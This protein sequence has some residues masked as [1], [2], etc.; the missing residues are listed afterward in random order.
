MA[1]VMENK[2][3]HL[4]ENGFTVEHFKYILMIM[5]GILVFY[6]PYLR[7]LYF[8][9]EQ[10]PA[11]IFSFVILVGVMIYK[12]INQDKVFLKTPIDYC[13][14]GLTMVYALSLLVSVNFRSG[15][16]E[17]LKYAFY[18]ACFYIASQ[19]FKEYRN[20][21]ALLWVI[22]VSIFGVSIISMDSAIGPRGYNSDGSEATFGPLSIVLNNILEGLPLLHLK[23]S[24]FDIFL[25][26]KIYSTLQYSNAFAAL[27]FTVFIMCVVLITNAKTHI[28]RFALSFM[29]Y[30]I[31]TALLF[32]QSRGVTLL[33]PFMLIFLIFSVGKGFRVRTT[34]Y[35]F[36]SMLLSIIISF[37]FFDYILSNSEN[38]MNKWL[39]L[40]TGAIITAF[41]N[42][43]IGFFMGKFEKHWVIGFSMLCVLIV[44][45]T[46]GIIIAFT[47]KEPL[48]LELTSN[49]PVNVK[50]IKKAVTLTGNTEYKLVF[51]VEG[52]EG[53]VGGNNY[54]VRVYDKNIRDILSDKAREI[55]YKEGVVTGEIQKLELDFKVSEDSKSTDIEFGNAFK[56]SI[57][58]FHKAE[59]IRKDN[60]LKVTDLNLKYKYLPENV[61]TRFENLNA[62][63]SVIERSTFNKDGLEIFKERWFMGAGGGAWSLLYSSKQS[64]YYTTTQAHNF[65]L[66]LAIET[67][68]VGLTVFVLLIMAIFI[69]FLTEYVLE[70]EGEDE[71][72]ERV[73]QGGLL[74]AISTMLIHSVFDFDFSLSAVFL[75]FCVLV[76]LLNS[77]YNSL[78]LGNLK[79]YR[80][81]TM[82]SLLELFRK[83][84]FDFKALK[85]SNLVISIIFILLAFIPLSLYWGNSYAELGRSYMNEEPEISVDIFK[86]AIDSDPLKA[87]YKNL[88]VNAIIKAKTMNRRDL[89][90]EDFY[91][92]NSNLKEA[93]SLSRYNSYD[94][95]STAT[96][97]MV[98]GEIEQALE[99]YKN[100]ALLTPR[101]EGD[102]GQYIAAFLRGCYQFTEDNKLE[103]AKALALR[104]MEAPK[105]AME[106]N[107]TNLVPF[108]FGKDTLQ[109]IEALDYLKNNLH[110][111]E[112]Y[113]SVVFYSFKERIDVDLDGIPDQWD[114]EASSELEFSYDNA[115]IVKSKSQKGVTLK[116]RNL[117]IVPGEKYNIE[118]SFADSKKPQNL[119]CSL[120]GYNGNINLVDTKNG[121]IG[122]F[123]IPMDFNNNTVLRID[124]SEGILVIDR[125]LLQSIEKEENFW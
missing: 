7:G 63:K 82:N 37:Q 67:G 39:L 50:L 117:E 51:Q 79:K 99:L 88:Y 104:A 97:Y 115:L 33:I 31:F 30:F 76:A 34:I 43:L 52:I 26:G 23:R 11:Q 68:V 12:G 74:T 4:E 84:S 60:G 62:A 58:I 77:R 54:Y 122:T 5:F 49:E 19:L 100:S 64:Y 101:R 75:L 18:F 8:E 29:G 98:I 118:I 36:F 108:S 3:K 55:A 72:L 1:K 61:V 59:I 22:V 56:N 20:K 125:I 17:F 53:Q 42:I 70:R 10:F 2:Q 116:T 73:L 71:P 16:S 95:F 65:I 106:Y 94:S 35:T 80:S 28:A 41:I 92:V 121:Y 14:F 105:L 47:Q 109:N 123:D 83:I 13:F 110:K 89:T 124:S 96:N 9:D 66:Q 114:L 113:Q 24:F 25:N 87:E 85:V 120:D 102:W 45:G 15:L 6:P 103:E 107:K 90:N 112:G 81:Q 48:K 21:V 119:T 91:S 40:L 93:V 57:V 38:A 69:M 44:V 111:K 46:V 78:N 86:K 32:S 27:A